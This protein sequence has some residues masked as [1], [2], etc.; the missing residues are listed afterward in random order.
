MK[1]VSTSG[2]DRDSRAEN[3]PLEGAKAGTIRNRS[4]ER[5]KPSAVRGYKRRCGCASS[6]SSERLGYRT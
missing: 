1:Y 5:Y 2:V 6:P 3:V 4:G